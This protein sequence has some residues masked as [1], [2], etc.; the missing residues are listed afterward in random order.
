ML[1]VC[2]EGARGVEAYYGLLF[3]VG[4]KSTSKVRGRRVTMPG[5]GRRTTMPGQ[6][7]KRVNRGGKGK[8]GIDKKKGGRQGTVYT[9]AEWVY[10]S[11]Y[12]NRYGFLNVSMLYTLVQ[13]KE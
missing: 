6:G 4:G 7:R 5:Q 1:P 13:I 9:Y 10:E 2:R 11:V 12:S 8:E 3:N